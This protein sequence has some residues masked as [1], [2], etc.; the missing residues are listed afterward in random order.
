MADGN[1]VVANDTDAAEI[2]FNIYGKGGSGATQCSG[3]LGNVPS[4]STASGYPNQTTCP[5]SGFDEYV[6]EF[7]YFGSPPSTT[8]TPTQTARPRWRSTSIFTLGITAT[9]TGS[10]YDVR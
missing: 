4:G 9:R 6:V 7:Y 8:A 10:G 1:I 2:S 3:V 5:V